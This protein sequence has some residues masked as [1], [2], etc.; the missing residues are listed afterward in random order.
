[1]GYKG[2]DACLAKVA[3]DEPIFVLR[4]QD[5]LAPTLVRMWA[6]LVE[7]LSAPS[8]KTWEARRLATEMEFWQSAHGKKIPD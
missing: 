8:E 3:P 5:R 4:S 6:E 2:N 1:M 7:L